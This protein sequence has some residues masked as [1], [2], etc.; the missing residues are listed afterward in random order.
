MSDYGESASTVTQIDRSNQ[1][2]TQIVCSDST[3]A[4]VMKLCPGVDHEPSIPLH[5]YR[6]FHIRYYIPKFAYSCRNR[7]VRKLVF[8]FN[9][10]NELDSF[11]L[12]DQIG[13]VLCKRGIAAA[14]IPLPDHLNRH[15]KWRIE[16]P[17]EKHV[18]R[19]P[20]DDIR[21]NPAVMHDRFLQF[22]EE[23]QA[24]YGSISNCHILEGDL[25]FCFYRNLFAPDLRISLFGHALGGLVALSIFLNNPECYNAC[26]LLNAGIQLRDIRLP[27]S[28]I[29]L[30]RW[31]KILEQASASFTEKKGNPFSRMYGQLFLQNG[32]AEVIKR[33]RSLKKR[34]LFIFGGADAA[35]PMNSMRRIEPDGKGLSIFQIPHVGE[36]PAIEPEW[37]GWYSLTVDLVAEFEENASRNHWSRQEM[38][39]DINAL[40]KRWEFFTSP[41]R[42]HVDRIRSQED[43]DKFY[44]I[45]HSHRFFFPNFDTLLGEAIL[46]A[47]KEDAVG[48]EEKTICLSKGG[49]TKAQKEEVLTHQLELLKSGTYR[50]SG[51]IAKNL[52]P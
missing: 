4:C 19:T 21:E 49:F 40:N 50:R 6:R 12:Y 5:D 22:A 30:A 28:M 29:S 39:E 25:P 26:F 1:N 9:G 24:L 16:V 10:L 45:Y 18:Q 46:Q 17:K 42:W 8:M 31:E 23:V 52:F 41:N 37:N 27:G 15:A 7:T 3:H 43:F 36:F 48:S 51:T 14:L 44:Q 38:I 13:Q 47:L 32:P 11:A 2:D 35:I 33:L 20:L 34:V